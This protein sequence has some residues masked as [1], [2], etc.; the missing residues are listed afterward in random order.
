[1]LKDKIILF[2]F[3]KIKKTSLMAENMREPRHYFFGYIAKNI[4]LM[5]NQKII[6]DSVKR[7]EIKN[8]DTVLEIGSG[9]G[10]GIKEILK[11]KPRKILAIEIS[12]IFRKLLKNKFSN[13]D[14]KIINCDAKNLKH[15]I[16]DKT[17]DKLLLINVIY[18]LDPIEIYLDEF[19]RILKDDGVVLIAGR[20]KAVQSFDKKIFKHIE[21]NSLLKVLN[22]HFLVTCNY[23]DLNKHNTKYQAITLKKIN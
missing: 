11:K 15:Y 2:I 22:K 18:F 1:M 7:L 6:E 9:N 20:F 14:I 13:E 19:K 8:I 21:L 3:N 4:M 23:I 5:S 12:S 16:N 17:I 10:Q